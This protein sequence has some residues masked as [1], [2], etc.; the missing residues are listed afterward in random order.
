MKYI[1]I[2]FFSCILTVQALAAADSTET[3]KPTLT[4]AAIYGSNANYY[5]QTAAERLPYVLT[6]ASLRFP[7]GFFISGSAYRLLNLG[8]SGVSA[9]D[10]SAG[11]NWD[12]TRNFTAGIAYA[13]SFYPENSPLLQAG[14]EN[15]ASA[16][17]GYDWQIFESELGAD[18]SFGSQSDVFVSLSNSKLIDLGSF[19]SDRGYF[20]LEPSVEIVGG[21]QQY[22]EEYTVRKSKQE[23]FQEWLKNPLAPPGQDQ[24][25]T[26]TTSRTSFDLLTYNVNIPI[27]YNRGNYL[28]EAGYQMSVLGKKVTSESRRPHSFFN[29]SFYYQF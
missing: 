14:N 2:A 21:T 5:G 3:K 20:T 23:K 15:T 24:T 25:E 6:N 19:G 27:G 13:R 12:V 7:A 4:L 18:Y 8:G 9:V 11:F 17:L 29:L 10:A 26:V 1:L 28:L 16:S 22:L